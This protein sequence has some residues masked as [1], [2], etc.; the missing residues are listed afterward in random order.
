M[1]LGVGPKL[2]SVLSFMKAANS[3]SQ[4]VGALTLFSDR[5]LWP[6]STDLL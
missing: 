1:P 2:V 5:Q 4:R 3:P 6:E